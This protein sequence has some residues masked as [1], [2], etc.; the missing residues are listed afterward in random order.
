VLTTDKEMFDVIAHACNFTEKPIYAPYR[1]G[2]IYRISL[3][4]SKAR[5]L[6][7]WKPKMTLE[8]GVRKAV[9][10]I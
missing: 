6:L 3:D 1:P 4:A 2:E 7:G 8:E 9:E 10:G 5:K